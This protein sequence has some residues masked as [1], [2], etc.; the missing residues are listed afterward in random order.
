MPIKEA[1]I[2]FKGPLKEYLAN[3]NNVLPT[4][5]HGSPQV[6]KL[7]QAHTIISNEKR[8]FLSGLTQSKQN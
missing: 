6:R 2:L 8:R 5:E 3:N 7:A 1:M 4:K